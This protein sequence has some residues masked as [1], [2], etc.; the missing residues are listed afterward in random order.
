[1]GRERH[2]DSPVALIRFSVR[3]YCFMNPE[4]Q[5]N[6]IYGGS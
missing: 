3:A 2:D 5:V 4:Q 6:G 1:M